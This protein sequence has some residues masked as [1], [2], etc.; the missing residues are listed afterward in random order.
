MAELK[1]LLYAFIDTVYDNDNAALV[2][3]GPIM[4]PCEARRAACGCAGAHCKLVHWDTEGR[5][6]LLHGRRCAGF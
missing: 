4:A 6:V 2:V 3:A 5:W 1:T